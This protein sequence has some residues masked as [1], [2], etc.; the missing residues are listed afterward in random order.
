MV[1][2]YNCTIDYA[3]HELSYTNLMLY[4]AVLPDYGSKDDKGGPHVSADDPE[5]KEI[6]KQILQGKIV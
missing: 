3:V 5:N 2:S 1:K 4:V 6:V